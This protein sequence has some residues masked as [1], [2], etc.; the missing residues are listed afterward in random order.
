M[1]EYI[2][3]ALV[4]LFFLFSCESNVY[5]RNNFVWIKT[6]QANLR[7]DPMYLSSVVAIAKQNDKVKIIDKTSK[8]LQIGSSFNYWYKVELKNGIQA[9]LY[10]ALLSSEAISEK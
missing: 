5:E 2:F 1:K 6:K 10:G 7:T 8:K 4:F 3:L 9:W